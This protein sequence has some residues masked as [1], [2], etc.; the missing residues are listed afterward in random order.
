MLERIVEYKDSDVRVVEC[1]YL[2]MSSV[3]QTNVSWVSEMEMTMTTTM[4]TTTTTTSTTNTTTTNKGNVRRMYA[5]ALDLDGMEHV[6]HNI[7]V[8]RVRD[9][10]FFYFPVS[11]VVHKKKKNVNGPIYYVYVAHKIVV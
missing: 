4:T 7:F 2:Y 8:C 10:R 5:K 9:R 6:K 11:L 1:L 3:R